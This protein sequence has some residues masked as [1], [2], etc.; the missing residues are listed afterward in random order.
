MKNYSSYYQIADMTIQVSSD[1]PIIKGT[2]QEKFNKFK[3]NGPG[4]VTVSINHHFNFLDI[5]HMDLGREVYHKSP[6]AIYQQ[7]DGWF[8]LGILQEGSGEKF[9]KMAKFNHDHTVGDIYH[10]SSEYWDKGGLGSLTSFPSDQILIARLLA[11]RK[12]F[13]LH[14][15][16]AILNGAGMLFVGHSGAGKSTISQMLLE[17]SHQNKL[18]HFDFELLCDDRNIVRR[19]DDGWQVYGS[20]SHGDIPE[21]SAS[22]AQLKAI[23][24]LEQAKNNQLIHIENR[25][26]RRNYL[27]SCIIKPL[28]TAS[29]WN[30]TLDGVELLVDDVPS[31]RLCFDKSGDILFELLR[32]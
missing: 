16:G 1:L 13:Y 31:Y 28:I 12:G 19:L 3:V 15:A 24:F 17:A 30:K 9:W 11:D 7:P 23:L 14:S 32:L 27:L 5:D 18:K 21:I 25:S 20:W 8:Y 4:R 10:R 26:D 29:W 22:S 6:W 2:F